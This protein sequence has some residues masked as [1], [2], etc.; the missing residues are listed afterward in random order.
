MRKEQ[1]MNDLERHPSDQEALWNGPGGRAWIELQ[2]ILDRVLQPFEDLLLDAAAAGHHCRVL[3]VGC[4]TGST[5]LAL[6]QRRDGAKHAVGIDISAPMIAVARARAEQEG[7]KARFVHGDA[8]RYAFEPSSFDMIV[9][10]FGVMFFDDPV[11]AFA[12]L[13]RAAS[14]D[15]RLWFV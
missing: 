4:G 7:S 6:A 10:R 2:T 8:Q 9:S 14:D 13:R 1:T 15:T 5:T 11:R 3:D 12:N